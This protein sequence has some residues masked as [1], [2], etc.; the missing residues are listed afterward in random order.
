MTVLLYP[1]EISEEQRKKVIEDFLQL[2]INPDMFHSFQVDWAETTKTFTN[3]DIL[4]SGLAFRGNYFVGSNDVNY[5]EVQFTVE[6]VYMRDGSRWIKGGGFEV[7][8][9]EYMEIADDLFQDIVRAFKLKH[10]TEN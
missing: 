10:N 6:S 7:N 1:Q 4:S 9:T 3:G 5:D 8:I 2:P